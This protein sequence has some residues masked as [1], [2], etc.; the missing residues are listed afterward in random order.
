MFAHGEEGRS[1]VVHALQNRLRNLPKKVDI[2]LQVGKSGGDDIAQIVG[3][4]FEESLPTSNRQLS[5]SSRLYCVEKGDNVFDA[6]VWNKP[7]H[8]E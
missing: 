2:A 5:G 1:L 7:P 6:L 4:P 8:M 3:Y